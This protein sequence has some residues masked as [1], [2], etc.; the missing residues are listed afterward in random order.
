V[1]RGVS[2]RWDGGDGGS[3]PCAA[4]ASQIWDRPR[5]LGTPDPG[6]RGRRVPDAWCRRGR[7]RHDAPRRRR[8]RAGIP[9]PPAPL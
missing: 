2:G 3:R 4:H 8:R 9:G 6:A 7:P 5:A 1:P